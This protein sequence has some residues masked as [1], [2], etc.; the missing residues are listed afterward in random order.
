MKTAPE[1]LALDGGKSVVYDASRPQWAKM[2][3]SV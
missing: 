2:E 1:I 3:I